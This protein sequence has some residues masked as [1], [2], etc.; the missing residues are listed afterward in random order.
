MILL[1][2]E[3]ISESGALFMA[4]IGGSMTLLSALVLLFKPNYKDYLTLM[5]ATG[6]GSGPILLIIGLMDVN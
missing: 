5:A 4:L 1:A 6:I 2:T 3:V